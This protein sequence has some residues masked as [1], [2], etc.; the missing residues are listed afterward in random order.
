ML[1]FKITGMTVK[2]NILTSPYIV[3]IHETT[4]TETKGIWT[5]KTI[6]EDPHKALADVELSLEVIPEVLSEE[7]FNTYN[8]FPAP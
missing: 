1:D 6:V 4:Y 7:H 5:I 8:V 2:D 3:D